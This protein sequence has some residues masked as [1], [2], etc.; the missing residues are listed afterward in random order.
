MR[1]RDREDDASLMGAFASR[2]ERAAEILYRRFS[3]RIYG[4][5]IVMLGSDAA[6]EDLVQDTFVK[7]WR[8]AGKYD[9]ARGKL[10]TW[11]LLVA[12]SLAIDTLR[13]RVLESRSLKASGPPPEADPSP[14]PDEI[15]EVGDMAS[16]ARRAMS[17]LSDEQ[18]AALE[19][20]YF[21]GK[22]SAEVAEM[23]GI[24]LGTAKTRIRTA[25]LRLR[26]A[27]T[28]EIAR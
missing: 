7:L 9:T 24:P 26:E 25:L 17:R 20:A 14:H 16:R 23:E 11:V 5:G 13:R 4:L 15:A 18:R 19:L 10:E 22:T 28:E 6:A 8:N 2:D 21:G 3:S 1:A 12:R 27:M